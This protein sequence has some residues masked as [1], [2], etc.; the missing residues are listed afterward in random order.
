LLR[1]SV[2]NDGWQIKLHTARRLL[3]VVPFLVFLATLT[4]FAGAVAHSP[5][6]FA[7]LVV[8]VTAVSMASSIVCVAIYGFYRY[9]LDSSH[10][11]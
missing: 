9:H 11:L 2:Y 4:V 10:G 6:A 5:G 8:R 3:M 7:Q 1:Y